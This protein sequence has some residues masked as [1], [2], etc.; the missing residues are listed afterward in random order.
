M[1]TTGEDQMDQRSNGLLLMEWDM[2][3]TPLCIISQQN[4]AKCTIV[5]LSLWAKRLQSQIL[6]NV[7]GVNILRSLISHHGGCAEEV[8]TLLLYS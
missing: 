1:D 5:T 4:G 3:S 8:P 2:E 7:H 6:L